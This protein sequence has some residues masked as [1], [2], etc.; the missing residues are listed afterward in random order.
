VTSEHAK[1]LRESLS[2]LPGNVAVNWPTDR[3]SLYDLADITDVF[4]NAWSAAGKEMTPLGIPVVA[5]AHELLV[6]PSDLHYIATSKPDYFEKIDQALRDGWSIERTRTAYRWYALEYERAIFDVHESFPWAQR[7]YSTKV[8]SFLN[9]ICLRLGVEGFT[10]WLDCMRRK[11]VK[12]KSLINSVIQEKKNSLLELVDFEATRA[13][14]EEET[15]ALR[16]EIGRLVRALY[17]KSSS[18]GGNGETLRSR[19]EKFASAQA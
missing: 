11:S 15:S 4:L 3:I 9:R 5:Y 6:Y 17:G 2:D 14:V 13:S 19:L 8:R 16:Q 7:R 12:E 1:S 10:W 18:A